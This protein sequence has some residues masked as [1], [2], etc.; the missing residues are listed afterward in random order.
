MTVAAIVDFVR[1]FVFG[2]ANGLTLGVSLRLSVGVCIELAFV[3]LLGQGGG[4]G[5]I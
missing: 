5:W 2:L 1:D 4:L 3:G